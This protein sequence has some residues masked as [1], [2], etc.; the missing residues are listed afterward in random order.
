MV[1]E[2]LKKKRKGWWEPE[3]E[4]RKLQGYT[5]S[6]FFFIWTEECSLSLNSVELALLKLAPIS[7]IF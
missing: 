2:D 3:R 1:F 7:S 6:T 4:R 5:A